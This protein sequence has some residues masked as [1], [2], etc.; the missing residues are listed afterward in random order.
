MHRAVHIFSGRLWEI[1]RI[2]SSNIEQEICEGHMALPGRDHTFAFSDCRDLLMK[3]EREIERYQS[4]GTDVTEM[5]DLAF[6]ISVT[7]W[8][9]CDWVY[10]DAASDQW[11]K[12]LEGHDHQQTM[13]PNVRR[14]FHESDRPQQSERRLRRRAFDRRLGQPGNGGAR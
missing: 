6:N 1:G 4:L 8:S 2:A 10:G 11:L 3:L 13:L 9:M 12:S 7:A 14:S 5:R